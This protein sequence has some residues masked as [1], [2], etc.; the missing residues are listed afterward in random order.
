MKV[1]LSGPITG[2]AAAAADFEKLAQAAR[3]RYGADA[4]I[5]SPMRHPAGLTPAAYMRMAFADIDAADVVLQGQDWYLSP[6]ARLERDY[7]CYTGTQI[8][9]A[10][11][12]DS[13]EERREME[14]LVL[15]KCDGGASGDDGRKHDGTR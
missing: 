2:K 10:S 5:L 3:E 6:G 14:R 13:E 7:A 15:G 12:W 1:Y 9:V 11:W 8:G 4:V